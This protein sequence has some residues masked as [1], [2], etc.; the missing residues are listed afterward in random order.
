M[1]GRIQVAVVAAALA[2]GACGASSSHGGSP[3]DAGGGTGGAAGAGGLV[4]DAGGAAGAGGL[5]GDA[6]GAASVDGGG[7]FAGDPRI[8]FKQTLESMTATQ[9]FDGYRFASVVFTG[10]Y[11][12]VTSAACDQVTQAGGLWVFHSSGGLVG[13]RNVCLDALVPGQDKS[14]LTLWSHEWDVGFHQQVLDDS[15]V[16]RETVAG[17]SFPYPPMIYAVSNGKLAP[18]EMMFQL[19]VNSGSTSSPPDLYYAKDL[20][21]PRVVDIAAASSLM[22]AMADALDNAAYALPGLKQ[23]KEWPHQAIPVTGVGDDVVARGLAGATGNASVYRLSAG[24]L[25]LV[26]ALPDQVH[27]SY[28]DQGYALDAADRSRIAIQFQT[29]SGDEIRIYHAGA[30]GLV[31]DRIL[32]VA[33]PGSEL[34]ALWG[35]H[36]VVATGTSGATVLKNGKAF[37]VP[38]IPVKLAN[39]TTRIPTVRSAAFSTDGHLLVT[40]DYGVYLYSLY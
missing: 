32:P 16:L 14:Q 12:F 28:P 4:G 25:Q 21:T 20:D 31:L 1:F 36:M 23:V 33:P 2:L 11:F 39:G 27:F 6:G 5:V 18:S 9:L 24:G 15:H 34:L 3:G 13:T 30:T 19:L 38:D 17:S 35:A 37:P 26:Q 7:G 10:K 29:A 8:T 40:T 22:V